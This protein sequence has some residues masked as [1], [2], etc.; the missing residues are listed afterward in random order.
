M[1][2]DTLPSDIRSPGT[3]CQEEVERSIWPLGEA[4]GLAPLWDPVL[5]LLFEVGY[6]S[7]HLKHRSLVKPTLV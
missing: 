5:A 2:S 7:C 3:V 6:Y 1:N 4:S